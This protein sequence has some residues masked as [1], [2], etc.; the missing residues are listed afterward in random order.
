MEKW[1]VAYESLCSIQ[2]REAKPVD[3]ALLYNKIDIV[4]GKMQILQAGGERLYA[5]PDDAFPD[6]TIKAEPTRPILRC[7][8]S[9]SILSIRGS[10]S[11]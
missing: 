5:G 7:C 10:S 3:C 8:N 4:E 1:S 9:R 11:L 2:F 6:S